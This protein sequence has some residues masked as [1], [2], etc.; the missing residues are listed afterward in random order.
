MNFIGKISLFLTLLNVVQLHL[1]FNLKPV[2]TPSTSKKDSARQSKTEII[3]GISYTAINTFGDGV[4]PGRFYIKDKSGKIVYKA[5]ADDEVVYF[6]FI[7]FNGDGYKDITVELRGVDSGAQDLIIYDVKSKAFKLAG[8]CSNAERIPTTKFYYTYEDCCMGRVWSSNL[9]YIADSKIIN[10][11]NIKYDDNGEYGISFY[12][13]NG[14]KRVFIK[15]WKVRI[16]GET[17]VSAG[18]HIDF[19][20]KHYWKNHWRSFIE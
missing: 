17:P 2:L 13:L 20:L 4:S 7:D 8:D 11:G 18:K 6:K 12:K 9:F 15:K 14:K 10:V 16:N 19:I 3:N 1:H 5:T